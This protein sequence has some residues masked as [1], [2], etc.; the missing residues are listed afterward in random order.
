VNGVHPVEKYPYGDYLDVTY[1]DP[2][3]LAYPDA[4]GVCKLT[5]EKGKLWRCEGCDPTHFGCE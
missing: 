5:F 1:K 4:N 3:V 2:R